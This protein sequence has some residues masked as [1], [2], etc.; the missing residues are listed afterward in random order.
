MVLA[1][2]G[3][4]FFASTLGV[5]AVSEDARLEVAESVQPVESPVDGR[6]VAVAGSLDKQVEAGELLVDLD[7]EEQ[8]LELEEEKTR[9]DGAAAQL[10]A[11]RGEIGATAAT[12]EQEVRT[13]RAALEEG[14]SKA[15]EAEASVV[16][17][18]AEA[19]KISRLWS[20]GQMPEIQLLRA[21]SE[22][23]RRGRKPRRHG[24]ALPGCAPSCGPGKKR[25]PC[26]APSL[27]VAWR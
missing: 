20:E 27:N 25:G 2:W 8:R 21:Q 12:V 16:L 3:L 7:R 9:R 17:A 14:R 1:A 10:E 18:D 5:Y 19:E 24:S 6:V 15:N 26:V 4:W 22:A 11:L 13:S 23:R